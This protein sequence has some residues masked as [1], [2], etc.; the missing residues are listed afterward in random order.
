MSPIS[1]I[2][3]LPM[4]GCRRARAV[5]SD[6]LDADLDDS[7]RRFLTAHLRHCGRCRKVLTTLAAVVDNLRTVPAGQAPP[8]G[9]LTSSVARRLSNDPRAP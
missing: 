1:H 9:S 5:L 3:A 8:G 2:R 7:N 6:H 4:I